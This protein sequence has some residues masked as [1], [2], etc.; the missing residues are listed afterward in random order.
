MTTTT[1]T[2]SYFLSAITSMV[3]SLQEQKA[4]LY[5]LI[6]TVDDVSAKFGVDKRVVTGL[7]DSE[8]DDALCRFSESDLDFTIEIARFK[9]IHNFDYVISSR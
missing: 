2:T 3:S 1:L 4:S 5:W 6:K 7:V 8:L 9:A